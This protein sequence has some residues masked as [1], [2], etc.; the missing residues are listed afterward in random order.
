MTGMR[1]LVQIHRWLGIALCL[2]FSMWFASGAI[3][4]YVPFPSLSQSERLKQAGNV[5]VSRITVSPAEA[6]AGTAIDTLDRVRLIARG[7][8]PLYVLH[9]RGKPVVAVWADDGRSGALQTQDAALKVASRFSTAPIDRID[10]P[11]AYDQWIVH[12]AFD[13]RRPF[14][15]AHANDDAGTIIYVSQRSGEVLQRTRRSERA[16]NYAGAVVHWIYPTVLRR[17][18]AAWDQVVWWL[19]LFGM[20]LA[21]IGIWLGIDRARI[22]L[23]SRTGKISLYRGWMRWHH[24]LGLCAGLFVLSWIFSGWLSMDHGRLFMLPDPTEEQVD[25][26][27]GIS[28]AKAA[29][30]IDVGVIQSL[31]SFQELEI[32]AVAG[33]GVLVARSG[34]E[35]RTYSMSSSGKSV[36]PELPMSLVLA[37]VQNAWPEFG[38]ISSGQTGAGDVY[39]QLRESKLPADTLRVQ[40]NDV[41][42]TWVHIDPFSGEILM[43]MDRGRRLYRWLFNGLHSLDFP[44][45]VNRRPL[46]DVV[47]VSLMAL[48]F[49]FSLTGAIVGIKHLRQTFKRPKIVPVVQQQRSIL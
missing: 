40:L 18:W 3:L 36:A 17:H 37:A 28:L 2:L 33:S 43:V 22:A 14:F 21:V 9:P 8:R 32:N 1:Y 11:L 26:F 24:V 47:I 23:R 39:S 13:S 20:L 19:S 12:N 46:W 44:G 27:R 5:D 16:W 42:E 49:T 48:G 10:G 34:S 29:E 4:I 6:I 41:G 7:S 15:R 38:V 31:G 25:R 45:L 30:N 35:Q